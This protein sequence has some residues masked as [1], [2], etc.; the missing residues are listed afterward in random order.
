[1]GTVDLPRPHRGLENRA[2]S[3]PVFPY[4]HHA[5]LPLTLFHILCSPLRRYICQAALP[6]CSLTHVS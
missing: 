5:L 2:S 1:M 3:L 6:L 4:D